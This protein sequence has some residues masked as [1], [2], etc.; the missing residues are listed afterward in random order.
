MVQMINMCADSPISAEVAGYQAQA[1]RL[2]SLGTL[3][4][5]LTATTTTTTAAATDA[6]MVTAAPTAPETTTDDHANGHSW[7]CES[8][9]SG[10]SYCSSLLATATWA[11][12][13]YAR[14]S[15]GTLANKTATAVATHTPTPTPAS[16]ASPPPLNSTWIAG[17]VV[18]SILGVATVIVVI[19]CTRRRHAKS[20]SAATASAKEINLNDNDSMHSSQGGKAQLPAECVPVKELDGREIIPP[21]ELPALEPVGSELSTPRD[22]KNPEEDWA[23]LPMSPLRVMF[24]EAELRD[25]RKRLDEEPK[26]DTFYH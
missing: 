5:T 1:S 4:A 22:G 18:G 26:H 15:G 6:S 10:D 8:A 13:F 12:Y 7:R 23:T 3:L 24:V 19:Y 9:T 25:Q 14:Q 16:S 17:P 21:V 11:S 2:S 20:L